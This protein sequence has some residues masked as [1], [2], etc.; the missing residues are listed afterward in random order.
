MAMV[1]TRVTIVSE[2]EYRRLIPQH[3]ERCHM[4]IHQNIYAEMRNYENMTIL[5]QECSTGF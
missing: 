5:C 2:L 1:T 4:R 3:R